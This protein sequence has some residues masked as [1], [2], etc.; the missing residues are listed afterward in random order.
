MPNKPVGVK[1]PRS[2]SL[3]LLEKM[4]PPSIENAQLLPGK[5]GKIGILAPERQTLSDNEV[6]TDSRGRRLER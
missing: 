5:P 6:S 1:V 2:F 4:Y 3:Q